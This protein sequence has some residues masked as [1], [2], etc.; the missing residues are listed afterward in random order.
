VGARIAKTSRTP[1]KTKMMNV[2]VVGL[3]RREKGE[4]R[5]D[6][7]EVH[8]PSPL[9]LY[10]LDLP[11]YGYAK[12]GR[13]ERAAFRRL[14]TGALERPRLTGVVWLLD[15]RHE[16]SADDGAMQE[17]LAH[18][19]T[20]VLAAFTKGDKLPRGQR[21]RRERELVQALGVDPEQAIVTSAKT[22]DGIPEL[23]EAI[24][25]FVSGDR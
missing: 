24:G 9:S 25:W 3:G 11:G 21:L 5:S 20:R 16:P 6:E 14:V 15:I 2:Y 17:F 19:A 1:G 13:G 23:R 7:R 22:G 12:A 8:L 10:L 18:R 4:G